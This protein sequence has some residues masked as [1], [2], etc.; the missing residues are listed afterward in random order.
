MV[1]P[2]SPRCKCFYILNT[3]KM[4]IKEKQTRKRKIFRDNVLGLR[5]AQIKRMVVIYSGGMSISNDVYDIVR[6]YAKGYLSDMSKFVFNLIISKKEDRKTLMETDVK[7]YFKWRNYKIYESEGHVFGRLPFYR[8]FREVFED[9]YA[10]WSS[11]KYRFRKDALI[12]AQA[13]LEHFLADLLTRTGIAVNRLSANSKG[14]DSRVTL[15]ASDL[16]TMFDLT[17][18]ELYISPSR[19]LDLKDVNVKMKNAQKLEN[20]VKRTRQR[21]RVQKG[22]ARRPVKG[23]KSAKGRKTKGKK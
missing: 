22:K 14:K 18:T 23:R 4:A 1:S 2:M 10:G 16:K 11:Y 19:I 8:L 21:A 17:W 12:L 3:Y 5:N 9:Y 6:A 7:E 15:R 13:G 20:K